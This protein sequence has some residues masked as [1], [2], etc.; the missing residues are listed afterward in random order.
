MSVINNPRFRLVSVLVTLLA[1]FAVSWTAQPTGADDGLPIDIDPSFDCDGYVPHLPTTI[2]GDVIT[3][4]IVVARDGISEAKAREIMAKAAE[5]YAPSGNHARVTPRV[6]LNV[7]A[8]HDLT[9]VLSG[10]EVSGFYYEGQTLGNDLMAQLIRYYREHYPNL[11]R[12]HVHLITNRDITGGS[13]GDAVAGIDNCIGSIGSNDSYSISESGTLD[14]FSLEGLID[15]YDDIDA[16]IAAH[17]IGHA[18][19]AHHHYAN[20]AE[21][22][23]PGLLAGTADVCSL[24]FNDVGLE[25]LRFSLLETLVIR[26]NAERHIAGIPPL[27]PDVPLTL[28]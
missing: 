20:C 26:A 5:P 25:N 12:D 22:L 7:V 11:K 24:M 27:L 10:R 17:E 15:F 21:Y 16:K 23:V 6:K 28:P 3:A 9:G 18:F 2:R 14:P 8:V 13:L 1:A 19:G 4:D